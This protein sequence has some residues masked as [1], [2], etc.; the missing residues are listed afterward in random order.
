MSRFADSPNRVLRCRCGG[1]LATGEDR[2]AY[3][4]G[5]VHIG[6][7]MKGVLEAGSGK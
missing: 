6:K 2:R 3:P 4:G 1:R 5:A 7:V